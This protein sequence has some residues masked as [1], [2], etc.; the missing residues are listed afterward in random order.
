MPFENLVE[1]ILFAKHHACP[2]PPPIGLFLDSFG[3]TGKCQVFEL[4]D[5]QTDI[6]EERRKLVKQYA[7][8]LSIR[9]HKNDKNNANQHFLLFPQCFLVIKMQTAMFSSYQNANCNFFVV[10]SLKFCCLVQR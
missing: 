4:L 10:C 7:P 6:K 1:T 3:V 2:P 8:N 9:G 5:R